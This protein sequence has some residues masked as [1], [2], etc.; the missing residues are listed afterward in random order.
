MIKCQHGCGAFFHACKEEDHI[1]ICI[2]STIACPYSSDGCSKQIQRK[3]LLHH[4]ELHQFMTL[5]ECRHKC[6]AVL[7]A[8]VEK[9]HFSMC[10]NSTVLCPYFS[11]GCSNHIARKDI[12]HHLHSQCLKGILYLRTSLAMHIKISIKI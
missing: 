8:Y 12:V 3:D 11:H 10:P 4:L 2:N 6:G 7:D 1:T 9:E 5:I